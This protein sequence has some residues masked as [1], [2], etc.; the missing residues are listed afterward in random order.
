MKLLTLLLVLFSIQSWASAEQK[1]KALGLNLAEK[2]TPTAN[3][4]Y[5]VKT[6]NL[7]FVSGHIPVDKKG[8]VVTG[9]LGKSLTTEQGAQA[10]RLAGESILATIKQE[11]GSLDK[12]ARLVKATG[13]VNATAEFTQHS[14]VIN[15]F[16]DLMVEVFGQQGK[17]ARAAVGM[18]SLPLDAAVEVELILEVKTDI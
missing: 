14:Q 8:K 18:S 12:V 13:M 16:S 6:G 9:K 3:F 10:A 15:G 2:G 7:L 17:H 4:V 1:A 11:L 5:A